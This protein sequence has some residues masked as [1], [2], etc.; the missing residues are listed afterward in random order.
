MKI[1]DHPHW[2]AV[3]RIYHT[4]IG[5]GYKAYLAG[6]CVRDFLLG[7]VAND[8]DIA[9][10]A[11]PDTIETL[12]PKTVAVGK[13]FGV[14][15]VVDEGITFEVATFRSDG[16]YRNG[17]HPESVVFT[18]PEED[19]QRRDFTVNAL[20]YDLH[21]GRVLDFVGG[22]KDLEE[23][24]LRAVGNPEARFR[25]D[26]LRL[27]RAVRFSA[28][29]DFALEPAT[30]QAVKVLSSL[31]KTVSPERIH[32]ETY[33]LLKSQNPLRGL[34]LLESTGLGKALFPGW[35]AVYTKGE[36]HFELLFSNTARSQ[37]RPPLEEEASLW[38]C[39]LAPW[40]L[41]KDIGWTR[42]LDQYRFSRGLNK[43]LRKALERL[44]NTAHFFMTSRGEQLALLQDPSVQ[45]FLFVCETL[46]FETYHLGQLKKQW[47]AW[48]EVMP[49]P[50]VR[51][52]DLKGVAEG[53]EIGNALH[54]CYVLQL[55]GQA[56]DKQ[57][58][59]DQVLKT[60]KI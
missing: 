37:R 50:W 26:H 12:F 2:P 24:I 5:N 44:E 35:S 36:K 16:I 51:A 14:I 17:R 21:E 47:Q 29:L 19:A 41:Q 57:A 52:E 58:L 31:V 20:F 9:T 27:L 53:R 43:S 25:E 32:E 11:T 8:L 54:R 7:R 13:A 55:E 59:L 6:G 28:Q 15:L 40:A 33:K 39:F 42:I 22:V 1:S 46:G 23:K 56:S 34:Q 38:M 4:L 48:G 49:A 10:D 18:T 60:L 3:Q 30:L 45:L